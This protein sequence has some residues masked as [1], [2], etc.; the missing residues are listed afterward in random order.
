M[1]TFQQTSTIENKFNITLEGFYERH[2][3]MSDAAKPSFSETKL[4]Q[5][6]RYRVSEAVI[7]GN[8]IG[9]IL[10]TTAIYDCGHLSEAEKKFKAYSTFSS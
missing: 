7:A 5:A 2:I 10:L 3:Q 6:S 4:A 1:S 8:V 9:P